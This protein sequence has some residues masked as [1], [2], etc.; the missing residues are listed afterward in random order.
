MEKIEPKW[1]AEYLPN[2]PVDIKVE[3]FIRRTGLR[4]NPLQDKLDRD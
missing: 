4:N 3:T 2:L 1:E